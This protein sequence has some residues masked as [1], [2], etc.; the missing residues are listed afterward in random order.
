[1]SRLQQHKQNQTNSR[2]IK[3]I[4]LSV[5]LLGIFFFIGLQSIINA[6]VFLNNFIRGNSTQSQEI[7]QTY[8]DFYGI[9]N[10]D[11]PEIATN[12]A[13]ISISGDVTEFKTVEF[14][15]NNVKAD[16]IAA[17]SN[18]TFSK[19]IGK[20][21]VGENKI[22]VLAKTQDNKH[23]KQSD[24]YSIIYKNEPPK[25]EIESP[26]NDDKTNK[27]E[28]QVKGKTD[29]DVT[30][31]INNSPVVVSVEGMFTSNFRLKDGE[32]KLEITATDIAGN[33]EKQEIKVM[34]EKD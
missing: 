1:M 10:V 8:A 4:I 23:K 2:I 34:Y 14:Y 18:G 20:L 22:Y 6:T 13:Q 17:K 30:V 7:Q 33:V 31:R 28:I 21:R 27:N 25:L 12:E 11:E 5:V 32:N 15:I 26:K 29:K 3:L 16:N 19:E 24:T 9:L